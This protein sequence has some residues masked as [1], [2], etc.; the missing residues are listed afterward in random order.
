MAIQ[1]LVLNETPL[2]NEP[3]FAGLPAKDPAIQSYNKLI[4]YA[5]FNIAILE[6]MIRPPRG[7][8]VF[9]PVMEEY[10]VT[11]FTKIMESVTNMRDT[12][13]I[14]SSAYGHIQIKPD[15]DTTIQR[16]QERY[17]RLTSKSKDSAA[18]A[19]TTPETIFTLPTIINGGG[20]GAGAAAITMDSDEELANAIAIAKLLDEDE[21]M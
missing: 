5:N 21:H 15:Y 2:H 7:F 11:N 3:G 9:I 1:A 17:T 18:T 19:A 10:F 14:K 12:N 6:M 8:E 4:S 20:A 16:L 13:I